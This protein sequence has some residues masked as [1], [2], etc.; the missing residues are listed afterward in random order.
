[1]HEAP[2][3]QVLRAGQIVQVEVGFRI[4]PAGHQFNL[5]MD[6]KS[7]AIINDDIVSVSTRFHGQ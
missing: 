5:R 1:M 4:V 3:G 7:V 2:S 6:L